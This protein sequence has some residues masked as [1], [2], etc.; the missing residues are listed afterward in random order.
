MNKFNLF[1]WCKS[2]KEIEYCI[3][4]NIIEQPKCIICSNELSFNFGQ[5]AKTCSRSCSWKLAKQNKRVLEFTGEFELSQI[6]EKNGRVKTEVSDTEFAELVKLTPFIQNLSRKTIQMRVHCLKMG[7]TAIPECAECS[8]PVKWQEGSKVF[9]KFCSRKC[10]HDYLRKNKVVPKN[11]QFLK[12]VT[13][14]Q[15]VDG[16]FIPRCS[17]G[18]NVNARLITESIKSQI[19]LL[20]PF[21]DFKEASLSERV[22]CIDNNFAEHPIC[23]CGNLVSFSKSNGFHYSQYCSTKCS[24]RAFHIRIG[25]TGIDYPGVVYILH[26][27]EHNAVK[28]GLSIDFEK[29]SKGLIKDFGEFTIVELIETDY[30]KLIEKELHEKFKNQRICLS[31]GTGRTEFFT[32]EILSS[33]NKDCSIIDK[34]N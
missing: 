5:Y 10:S 3:K 31:E 14:T 12:H 2:Q 15:E 24:K 8:N 13:K 22:Y 29:R 4:N 19:K 18:K 7:I 16:S 27:P 21:L 30:C 20:T 23:Y 25:K 33:F 1:N 34:E 32:E 9:G 28:I 26:F 11:E 6:F 17:N